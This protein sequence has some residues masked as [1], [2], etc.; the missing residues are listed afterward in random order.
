MAKVSFLPDQQPPPIDQAL[1]L[2]G[3]SAAL[4]SRPIR[5]RLQPDLY[6]IDKRS[7]YGWVGLT[8][9]LDLEDIEE[10]RRFR[11]G[12]G[13]FMAGFGDPEKQAKLLRALEELA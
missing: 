4:A 10:G 12:L 7:Y 9:T 2:V 11:E 8:W 3:A 6:D 13:R 5:I 1:E